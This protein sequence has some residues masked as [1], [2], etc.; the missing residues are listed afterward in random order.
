MTRTLDHGFHFVQVA[1]RFLDGDD[2]GMAREFNHHFSWDVVSRG[3]REVVDDDRERRPVGD[4]AI[5]SEQ[6]R[7][8]HLLLVVMRSAHHGGVVAKL[9]RIFG[10]AQSSVRGF[11]ARA[12]D[13]H[14]VRRGGGERRLQHVAAFLVREQDG[15]AG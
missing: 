8:Q 12:G 7:R 5:K 9:G 15:F 10:E 2:V 13:H 14:F 6:V 1:T 11:D 4:G 3:L